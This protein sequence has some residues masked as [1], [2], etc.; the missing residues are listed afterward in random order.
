VILKAPELTLPVIKYIQLTR[1]PLRHIIINACPP[2][3]QGQ[4]LEECLTTSKNLF[5]KGFGEIKDLNKNLF[6]KQ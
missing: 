1:R 2:M 6:N 3:S 4:P 5:S